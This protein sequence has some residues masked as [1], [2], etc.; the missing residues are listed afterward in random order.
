M[1]VN[2]QFAVRL[3]VAPLGLA[4]VF[5]AGGVAAVVPAAVTTTAATSVDQIAY[6]SASTNYGQ[7][8][9]ASLIGVVGLDGSGAHTL[10]IQ[11]PAA[12]PAWN[13]A[14]TLLA[15][16][17]TYPDG[18]VGV[19]IFDP[20]TST[21]R[22]ITPEGFQTPVWSPDGTR[23]AVVSS[24][25]LSQNLAVVAVSGGTPKTVMDQRDLSFSVTGRP[26]WSPD[27]SRIAAALTSY[28]EGDQGS[29]IVATVGVDG[30]G[31]QQAWPNSDGNNGVSPNFEQVAWSPD[32]DRL[33]FDG[34]TN[35]RD[36][37]G[38][39]AQV[40]Q[41]IDAAGHGGDVTIFGT[42]ADIGG[43]APDGSAAVAAV[44][45][46]IQVVPLSG[47]VASGPAKV[48]HTPPAGHVDSRPIFA[49][50]GTKVVFC[51]TDTAATTSD[52]YAVHADGSGLLRL[53]SSGQACDP[54]VAS[55][56][57]R[58]AGATR[59]DTAISASR[60]T[61]PSAAAV[62]IARDDLYPDALAAA[63]LAGKVGGP[64]LLSP[65]TG[66]SSVLKA[67]VSR[68]G[69][70]T[71]YVIGDTTALAAQVD[72]DLRASGVTTIVRI[73]GTTRYD[74]AAMIATRV[75]GT[76]AY[77]VRGDNWPDAASVSAL[78][79]FL[80]RAVLL[81]PQDSL[82]PAA[83]TA[84][85]TMH[86]TAATIVGGTAAVGAAAAGSLTAA[87]VAV[88]RIAG[89]DRWAT[90][91][92]VA[93]TAVTAGMT[94]PPWLA[95]GLNWPDAVGAGPAAGFAHG[96]L[97]LVHP[98]TLTGSPASATWLAQHPSQI[99]VAVGGPDVVSPAD[100]VAAG[101]G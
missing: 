77:V 100:V 32:G 33:L 85:A 42:D 59:V 4:A 94:G 38:T 83:A 25:V 80:H 82:S 3:V 43:Y 89:A 97:L 7:V 28:E 24:L 50:N 54:A 90:S 81:T 101:T 79:A 92:A 74:T 63:P 67:E 62:V 36:V 55:H 71:A 93:T 95:D 10:S 20:V 66:L 12:E 64:L 18:G 40:V 96:V 5:S 91:A 88:T 70:K 56:T 31:Y 49:A 27:G 11:E 6:A 52:L 78:A 58:F 2:R 45:G 44:G 22:A 37:A 34:N 47:A 75:G 26:A 57:P 65:P 39:G 1:R 48:V 46:A 41:S 51:E 98:T 76:S 15:F 87:G 21:E 29:S 86:V 19:K 13:P 53:T 68:L 69:A 99:V 23:I 8:P 72:T 17:A 16:T 60:A 30:S 14:G 35:G 9:H 61:Y 73:G 84:I